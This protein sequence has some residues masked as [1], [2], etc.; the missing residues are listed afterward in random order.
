MPIKPSMSSDF[1]MATPSRRQI[2]RAVIA[3]AGAIALGGG[4]CAAEGHA[5]PALPLFLGGGV[6]IRGMAVTPPNYWARAAAPGSRRYRHP[7]YEGRWD[8]QNHGFPE[9]RRR[10]ALEAGFNTI[11]LFLDAGPFMDAQLPG[12]LNSTEGLLALMVENVGHFVAAGFKV[13]LNVNAE[14]SPPNP[15]FS[16]AAVLDGPE[17]ENFLLYAR[18][19]GEISE[20]VGRRFSPPEVAIELINEPL[21]SWEWG[22]RAPWP[23]QAAALWRKAREAAP[24]HSLIVQGRD[25]GYYGA[26]VEFDSD[27]FDTNTIF[28]FHPYDPGGFTHQGIG[29]NRG[30]SGLVFPAS[31]HPGGVQAAR[32]S[33]R[34]AVAQLPGLSADRHAALIRH[35]EAEL[36]NIFYA[37]DPMSEER[38]DRAWRIID[39]WIER[40]GVSPLQVLAGEFGVTGDHNRDG[41]RGADPASRARFYRAVRSNVERRGFAGWIAWQSVGDF[42]LFEQAGPDQHG[43]RLIPELAA[44][45][46]AGATAS[47]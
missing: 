13:V 18:A 29:K 24:R 5:L 40:R 7:P 38:M 37:R 43:D 32:A 25:A 27:D 22:E 3:G 14:L 21:Y 35:H 16:R 1:D 46:G 2:A 44:A 31:Q 23:V 41:S 15:A 42:N 19:L 9:A 11:R 33:M 28:C 12:A 8:A 6:R 36:E 17:G 4:I 34:E 39:E 30:L 20:A 47:R 26:L 10:A 45:L